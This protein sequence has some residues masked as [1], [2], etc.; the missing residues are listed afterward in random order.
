MDIPTLALMLALTGL[1]SFLSLLLLGLSF[2]FKQ[3][4][5][6]WMLWKSQPGIRIFSYSPASHLGSFLEYICGQHFSLF[7]LCS[8]L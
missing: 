6:K 7:I 2:S 5:L 4:T 3:G 8:F 1:L